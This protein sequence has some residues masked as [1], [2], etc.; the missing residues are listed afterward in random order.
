MP[1]AALRE[2]IKILFAAQLAANPEHVRGM[3]VRIEPHEIAATRPEVTFI[4]K[5]IMRLICLMFAKA[6]LCERHIDERV[7]GMPHVQVHDHEQ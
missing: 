4:R 5:K 7:L 1:L 3:D 6:E 2:I